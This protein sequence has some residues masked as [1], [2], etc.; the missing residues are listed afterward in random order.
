MHMLKLPNNHYPIPALQALML[1]LMFFSTFDTNEWALH[2]DDD[3]DDYL[4]LVIVLFQLAGWYPGVEAFRHLLMNTQE[5][6]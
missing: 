6:I 5:Y 4:T 1:M 3:D 2:G